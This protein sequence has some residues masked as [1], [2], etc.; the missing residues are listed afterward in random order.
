MSPQPPPRRPLEP[1]IPFPENAEN[2][3]WMVTLLKPMLSVLQVNNDTDAPTS[4]RVDTDDSSNHFGP[5][6][7]IVIRN[8]LA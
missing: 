6:G 7:K 5:F 1:P 3:L 4:D 8:T 2:S